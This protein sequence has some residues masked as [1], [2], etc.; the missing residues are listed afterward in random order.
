MNG[1]LC[2][3]NNVKSLDYCGDGQTLCLKPLSDQGEA[4]LGLLTVMGL[5]SLLTLVTSVV[6]AVAGTT[7]LNEKVAGVQS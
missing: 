2:A 1:R 5:V 7:V 4:D 3:C 6:D